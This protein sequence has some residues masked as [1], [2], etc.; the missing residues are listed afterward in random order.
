MEEATLPG[1][2]TWPLTGLRI[3]TVKIT[4]K[5]MGRP[6]V[7]A[8]CQPKTSVPCH[9]AIS[10]GTPSVA[11][12]FPRNEGSKI[13]GGGG[14][15]RGPERREVLGVIFFGSDIPLLFQYSIL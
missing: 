2:F 12:C 1:S 11:A 8:G 15:E 5:A 6:Q 7:L 4:H 9:A 10:L 13:N 14:G 3:C